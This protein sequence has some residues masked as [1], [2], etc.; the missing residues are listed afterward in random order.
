[1]LLY[2]SLAHR[3]CETEKQI[4]AGLHVYIGKLIKSKKGDIVYNNPPKSQQVCGLFIIG[5]WFFFLNDDIL[6]ILHLLS[7]RPM[8]MS[9]LNFQ[10]SQWLKVRSGSINIQLILGINATVNKIRNPISINL[11]IQIGSQGAPPVQL[12]VYGT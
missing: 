1:M 9:L 10:I 4:V 5:C 3:T 8:L 11:E 2:T 7:V 6:S 12:R